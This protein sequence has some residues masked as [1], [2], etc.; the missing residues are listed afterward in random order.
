LIVPLIARAITTEETVPVIHTPGT[1]L[2]ANSGITSSVSSDTNVPLHIAASF[3]EA[4]IRAV[5]GPETPKKAPRS[6]AEDEMLSYIKHKESSGNPTA[7]NPNST[8]YG[9]YG[10]LD[11]TW[12]SVGCVKTADPVEQERCAVLYMEQRYGGIEG[13]YYFHLANDWY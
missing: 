6:P 4:A 5:Y 2:E 3:R 1:A 12:S 13:A 11:Q 8:A 9:L 7:Q 10:F